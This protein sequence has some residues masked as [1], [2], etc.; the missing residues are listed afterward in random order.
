MPQFKIHRQREAARANFRFAP[1]TSGPAVVKQ[2]DYELSGEMEAAS[3][4]ALFNALRGSEEA[5][6]VGD[7]VELPDGALKIYKY[8]GLEDAS[9]WVPVAKPE[10]AAGEAMAETVS[11]SS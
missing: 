3:A 1:H 6:E 7:V 11:A 5:L 8:V 9:W 4:Y 10:F 2:K